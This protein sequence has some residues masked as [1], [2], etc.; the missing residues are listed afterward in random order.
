MQRATFST[1]TPVESAPASSCYWLWIWGGRGAV[2]SL[3]SLGRS[4]ME[5]ER[6]APGGVLPS[7][8]GVRPRARFLM[9]RHALRQQEP[10]QQGAHRRSKGHEPTP[11]HQAVG[12]LVNV[13]LVA[14]PIVAF[15]LV[16]LV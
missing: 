6:H 8:D 1:A 15:T 2:W 11:R 9:A 3:T 14:M 5:A 4:G 7:R 16:S 10:W 13:N 12:L